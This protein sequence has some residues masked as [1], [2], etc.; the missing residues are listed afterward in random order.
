MIKF[1]ATKKKILIVIVYTNYYLF[2]WIIIK[3]LDCAITFMLVFK[4][5]ILLSISLYGVL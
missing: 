4:M 5:K 3:H 1:F 2:Y